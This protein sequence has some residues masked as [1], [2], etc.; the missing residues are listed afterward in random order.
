MIFLYG[1][2]SKSGQACV[3]KIGI[4]ILHWFVAMK[5][6]FALMAT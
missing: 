6:V 4:L 5:V 2:F 1:G 3:V